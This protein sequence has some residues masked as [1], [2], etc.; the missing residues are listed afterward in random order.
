MNMVDLGHEANPLIELWFNGV[1]GPRLIVSDTLTLMLCNAAAEAMLRD[2]DVLVRRGAQ[3]A[4]AS[5]DRQFQLQD[6]VSRQGAAPLVLLSHADRPHAVIHAEALSGSSLIA[7]EVRQAKTDNEAALPN[8]SAIYGLTQSEVAMVRPLL[9]GLSN[10][11]IAQELGLSIETVRTHLK[12]ASAKL[13]VS[14]R[15][16]LVAEINKIT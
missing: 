11:E 7:L 15:G 12:N 8:L 2:G 3:L 4:C 10:F 6:L 9:K 13:G 14:G 5:R 16:R 1:G